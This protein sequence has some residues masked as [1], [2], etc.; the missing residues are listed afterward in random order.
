V[1]KA[2]DAMD[3]LMRS[4]IQMTGDKIHQDGATIEVLLCM[5][6]R[7]DSFAIR[8]IP[9]LLRNLLAD[10]HDYCRELAFEVLVG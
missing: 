9:V 4:P 7:G 5:A 6:S 3:G 1:E 8:V 2:E 10:Y